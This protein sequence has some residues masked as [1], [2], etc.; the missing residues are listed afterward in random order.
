MAIWNIRYYMD[1]KDTIL[2][3]LK[4]LEENINE[5]IIPKD[6][7]IVI[8]NNQ[9]EIKDNNHTQFLKEIRE[10]IAVLF[11]GLQSVNAKN[12]ETKLDITI[13]FLQYLLI[14]LDEKIDE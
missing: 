8:S 5:D 11:E 6:D 2:Q 3:T 14:K 12:I 9:N 13:N 4:E 10:R 1:L 7:E